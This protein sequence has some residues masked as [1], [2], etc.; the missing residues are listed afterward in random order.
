MNI[1]YLTPKTDCPHA[2]LSHDTAQLLKSHYDTHPTLNVIIQPSSLL[3]SPQEGS[4]RGAAPHIVHLFGKPDTVAVHTLRQAHR[5]H[6]PIIISPFGIT[7]PPAKKLLGM[8]AA[9]HTISPT[10]LSSLREGSGVGLIP[11]PLVTSTIT[12]HE[13]ADQIRQLYTETYAASND[14]L[15][16]Q[17]Q[18][19]CHDAA[20]RLFNPPHPACEEIT[21]HVVKSKLLIARRALTQDFLHQFAQLLVNQPYNEEH[22]GTLLR[23]MKLHKHM[24]RLLQIMSETSQLTEG[25]MPMPPIDDR[26]TRQIRKTII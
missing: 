24:G 3:P 23:T 12:T 6:I 22:L 13:M 21:F 26:I 7:N 4:W 8:A 1:L 10:E 11:T 9:V 17:M 20:S 15:T 16:R 19:K 25:F 5:L 14:R 2:R 18:A